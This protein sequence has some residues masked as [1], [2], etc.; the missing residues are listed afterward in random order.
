MPDYD[1]PDLLQLLSAKGFARW[2][3]ALL[4]LIARYEGWLA[5]YEFDPTCDPDLR[6]LAELIR[7]VESL[8]AAIRGE[9]I[10]FARELV[11]CC[12]FCCREGLDRAT[13]TSWNPLQ[14]SYR[15]FL[16]QYPNA[17]PLWGTQP[18]LDATALMQWALQ[19]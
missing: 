15:D 13:R 1:A 11:Q 17:E 19:P 7:L 16:A 4:T 3:R 10:D 8:P 18:R 6:P 9:H 5:H 14:Q 12:D 2:H